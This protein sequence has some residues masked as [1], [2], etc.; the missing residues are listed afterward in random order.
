MSLKK[1]Q[2]KRIMNGRASCLSINLGLNIQTSHQNHQQQNKENKMTL[3][4][5]ARAAGAAKR[6]ANPKSK[7][8]SKASAIIALITVGSSIMKNSKKD[9]TKWGYKGK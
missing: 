8:L 9:S 6:L 2:S 7:P 5:I 4:Q 1:Y 3:Y